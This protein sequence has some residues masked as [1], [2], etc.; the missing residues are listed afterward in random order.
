MELQA[1]TKRNENTLHIGYN[2]KILLSENQNK[3]RCRTRV[4]Y[5]TIYV[6][7]GKRI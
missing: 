6:K 5:A 3:T 7:K 4:R 1:A 2:P